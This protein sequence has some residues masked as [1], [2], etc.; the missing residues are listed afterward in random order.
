MSAPSR[1]LS[2]SGLLLRTKMKSQNGWTG[3]QTEGRCS[4]HR[5]ARIP[6]I[7]ALLQE[8]TPVFML[9]RCHLRQ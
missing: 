6:H 1:L 4:S 3:L 2:L 7:L 5:W 8:L 9:T